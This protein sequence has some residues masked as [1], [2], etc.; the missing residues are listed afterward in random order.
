MTYFN[1]HSNEPKELYQDARGNCFHF[2]SQHQWP[3]QENPL[4]VCY[5]PEKQN[6]PRNRERLKSFT[7]H[8]EAW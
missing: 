7:T 2:V 1:K 4:K 5:Y 8:I 3:E 6:R